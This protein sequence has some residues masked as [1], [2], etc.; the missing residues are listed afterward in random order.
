MVAG[1]AAVA[2]V[3][4]A[5]FLVAAAAVEAAAEAIGAGLTACG[6][7]ALILIMAISPA[8]VSVHWQMHC[9]Y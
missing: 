2:A 6:R 7:G 9:H 8:R 1:A 5:S 3:A 4:S